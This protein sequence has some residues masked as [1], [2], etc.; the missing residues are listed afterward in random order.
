MNS[1]ERREARYQRRKAKRDLK[2]NMMLDRLD[3]FDSVFSFENIYNSFSDCR[4]GIN[5]KGSVKAY[6]IRR[7]KYSWNTYSALQKLSY[8]FRGFVEFDIYERGK[9][10]E[11]KSIH[12]SD[13]VVQKCLCNSLVPVLSNGFVY[14]NA[15]SLKGKGTSMAMR[16]FRC[17]LDRHYRKYG[18]EG[19]AL[20]IDA[21]A[22]FDNILH[23][24]VKKTLFKHYTDRRI[25]GLSVMF[26]RK[27]NDIDGR[28][29][30][31]GL[32]LGCQPNQIYAVG[33]QNEI[34]HYAER[35][36]DAEASIRYMDD[37]VVLGKTKEQ[38]RRWLDKATEIYSKL[39]IS[40]NKKKTQIV[41]ISKGV[42][43]LKTMH[44]LTDTGKI[45]RK[46]WKRSITKM[47]RKLKKMK[48]MLERGEISFQE[49]RTSYNS[50][51]GHIKQFNAY[52]T[53]RNMNRLFDKL[54]IDDWSAFGTEREVVNV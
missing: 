12:I 19:Y 22:Y 9:K 46:P 6:N 36:T 27:E 38:L 31:K 24:N 32:S 14:D 47:R 43:F 16:R 15:A 54:F 25:L 4:K 34:D 49:I 37:A 3:D 8:K 17:M 35:S 7:L 23:D 51:V 40:L 53:L 50:W 5:W 41:K 1:Q 21:S 52:R 29:P 45:I 10:R 30:G 18:N 26:L 33:Y 11:I 48:S 13:R 28:E 20:V 44:Y 39:G 42:K 2:R